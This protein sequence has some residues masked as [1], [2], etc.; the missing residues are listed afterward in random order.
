MEAKL[1]ESVCFRRLGLQ[2]S[3]LLCYSADRGKD[4]NGALLCKGCTLQ[5]KHT[6]MGTVH[7]VPREGCNAETQRTWVII[8]SEL[9]GAVGM[10]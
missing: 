1:H 3:V 2:D 4:F 8:T 10:S 7:F 6:K 9:I 5:V